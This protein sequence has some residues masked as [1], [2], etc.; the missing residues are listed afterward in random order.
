MLKCVLF[1][2]IK[3]S[4][5]PHVSCKCGINSAC[6]LA[7]ADLIFHSRQ[8]HSSVAVVKW[9]ADRKVF[10]SFVELCRNCFKY[11][12]VPGNCN[13]LYPNCTQPIVLCPTTVTGAHST[14]TSIADFNLWF[15]FFLPMSISTFQ[16]YLFSNKVIP[17]NSF[18]WLSGWWSK[19]A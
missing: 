1:S 7:Q 18:S 8:G 3:L 19:T 12:L 11:L 6:S 16:R 10:L 13:L 4:W 14:D 17:Q 5:L 15:K 2:V 9:S